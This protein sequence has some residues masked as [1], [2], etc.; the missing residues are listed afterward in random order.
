MAARFRFSFAAGLCLAL[1]LWSATGHGAVR[2]NV[3][4]L[5]NFNQDHPAIALYDQGLR[6][7]LQAAT[8]YDVRISTE[9][10]NL[11]GLE[12]EPGYVA[13]TA[14]YLV[15]KYSLWKPDAVVLDNAVVGL[16]EKYLQRVF[17]D[18]PWVVPVELEPGEGHRSASNRIDVI[19]G[20]TQEDIDRNLALILRLRPGT[21]TVFLVLGASTQER[22]IAQTAAPVLAKYAD[23]LSV[24]VTDGMRHATLLD[25]VE[26]APDDAAVLYLRFARDASGDVFIPATVAREVTSRAKIP[27]FCLSGHL[28]GEGM[29]GG[30]VAEIGA[31]G[32]FMGGKLL[33][34]LNG[35][36][37]G[38]ELISSDC[39]AYMFDGRVLERFG[40][41]AG[42]L[43]PGSRVEFIPATLW[44]T[45]RDVVLG[46]VVLVVAETF[47]ILGLVVNRLRRKRAEAALVALNVTLEQRVL[48][49]T[50]AL[51]ESNE[52]LHEAK[53]SLEGL[54]HQLER[55][56]RTDSLTGLPNRR[57]AEAFAAAYHREF[58]EAGRVYA[59]A[60]LDVDFFKRIN[61]R[62]GHEAG[63]FLLTRLGREMTALVRPGDM[64]ARWG[65]EE[66]LLVLPGVDAAAAGALASRVRA[67]I[68]AAVYDWRGLTL[69]ATATIGFAVVTPGETL[70]ALLR[71]ADA[72][73]YRGKQA[74]R[75]R[76]E[77]A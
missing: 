50:R 7:A 59:V 53:E 65:G 6:Q 4:V 62:H 71:R 25:A 15:R 49:R 40:I 66:F 9:Y 46:S 11:S 2:K 19:W 42:K 54:N 77:A 24:V 26:H 14:A 44:Q 36:F 21:K 22:R 75:D 10:L 64:T 34:A 52:A 30:Y 69:S 70:S 58:E 29:I 74:G 35:R 61:D 18:V 3:L 38:G 51:H 33:E 56:S 32:R 41:D 31:F 76:V 57:Q 12:Q 1:A 5:H 63:D 13:D 68:A 23:R 16:Y 73:L 27:V 17:A 37:V 72:A 47:L 20:V 48:E 28:L 8:D 45:H 55:L 43:P 60:M 39:T 67:G